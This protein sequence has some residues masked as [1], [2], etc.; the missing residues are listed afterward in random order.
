MVIKDFDQ[1]LSDVGA[2]LITPP[3]KKAHVSAK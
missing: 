3:F 2:R 1:M